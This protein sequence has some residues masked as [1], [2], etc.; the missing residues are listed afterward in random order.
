MP[1]SQHVAL[2]ST[3]PRPSP[4]WPD[5]PEIWRVSW[6]CATQPSRFRLV[7]VVRVVEWSDGLR[8]HVPAREP[9]TT[10]APRGDR[11]VAGGRDGGDRPGRSGARRRRARHGGS[12]PTTSPPARRRGQHHPGDRQQHRHRPARLGRHLRRRREPL[13]RGR[14]RRRA[15]PRH[16]VPG[17]RPRPRR[18][19]RRL[20]RGLPAPGRRA[21]GRALARAPRGVA[22]HPRSAP[23]LRADQR[24]H[25]RRGRTP[26]QRG[27]R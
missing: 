3:S 27:G 23:L 11:S 26:S 5:H 20:A 13:D 8:G 22:D 15:S 14:P 7:G 21:A 17:R 1:R 24:D 6:L 4:S 18:E 10:P 19:R 25:P 2:P 12:Q 9:S 16:R